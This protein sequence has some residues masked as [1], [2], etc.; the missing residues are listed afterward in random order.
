MGTYISFVGGIVSFSLAWGR[1]P[2]GP[3][4]SL[5]HQSFAVGMFV[6]AVEAVLTGLSFHTDSAVETIEWQ[7]WR[8]LST[9]FLPGG[10]LTFS[11]ATYGRGNYKVLLKKYRWVLIAAF[12]IPVALWTLGGDHFFIS[13]PEL[14]AI[15][16]GLFR[17]GQYGYVFYLC[18]LISTV[19]ILMNL[20]RTL[21][22][23]IGHVTT[24]GKIYGPRYRRA[25]CSSTAYTSS[26][27]LLFWY[28]DMTLQLLNAGALIVA[29]LHRPVAPEIAVA[30]CEPLSVPFLCL[31]LHHG[32]HRGDLF[33]CGQSSGQCDDLFERGP[34]PPGKGLF[35][36]YCFP[37]PFNFSPL[38]PAAA[39][40]ETVCK[41]SSQKAQVRLSK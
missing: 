10:W 8:L 40:D 27:V 35:C 33:Y 34:I 22:A 9:A 30:Q 6:L 25:L 14:S 29:G 16:Q 19:L 18:L 11:L 38:G 1:I 39:E 12:I 5:S 17:L 15:P 31:P 21:R 32:S 13:L 24:A 37:W 7:R 26:H 3:G 41:P 36:L 4:A 28:M 2:T 20:E 23:S